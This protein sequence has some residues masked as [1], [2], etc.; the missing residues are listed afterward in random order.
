VLFPTC[1]K[2]RGTRVF[3]V[4]VWLDY[5]AVKRS[6]GF[7]GTHSSPRCTH[8]ASHLKLCALAMSPNASRSVRTSGDLPASFPQQSAVMTASVTRWH[9]T[10]TKS[11]CIKPRKRECAALRRVPSTASGV[12]P[13]L[14]LRHFRSVP[15]KSRSVSSLHKAQRT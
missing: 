5:A 3:Y 7:G 11:C 2:G 12:N 9:D 1:P 15:C 14:Q 6:V 13:L 8:S 4:N 10:H